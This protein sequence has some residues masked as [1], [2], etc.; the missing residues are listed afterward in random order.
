MASNTSQS[1][2]IARRY[3]ASFLDLAE[4]SKG[5]DK[6][7]KDLNELLAMLAASEELQFL[8]RNP[9]LGREDKKKGIFAIADA[10]KF[11]ALTKSFLGVLCDNNRLQYLESIIK[12]V[13]IELTKRRGEI[14]AGVETAFALTNEQT[15]ELQKNLSAALGSNVTLNVKVNR[16]LLGGMVVTV[17]SR[18]Y[19]DSVR[20]K[21]ERLQRSMKSGSNL[22][23]VAKG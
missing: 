10:A 5:L 12:A 20:R 14:E 17:G 21:L 23:Q 2:Q 4:E 6:A 11:E 3:A 1:S 13:Q 16:D 7:E 9:L 22:Q 18:M 15:K 8:V 19:D